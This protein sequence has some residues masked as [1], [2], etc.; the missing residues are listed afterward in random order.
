M[1]GKHVDDLPALGDDF[2]NL[3]MIDDPHRL[4]STR[5]R[6]RLGVVT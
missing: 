6:R 5:A 1:I 3:T 4:H 2:Q